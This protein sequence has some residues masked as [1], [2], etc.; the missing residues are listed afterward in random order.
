MTGEQ[1]YAIAEDLLGSADG[2][3]SDTERTELLRAAQ[4]HATLAVAYSSRRYYRS[5][6]NEG[7]EP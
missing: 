6:A 3:L 7:L 4:V 5:A 1:H 2:A